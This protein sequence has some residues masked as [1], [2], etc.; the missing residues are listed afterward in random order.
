VQFVAADQGRRDWH[1]DRL[2]GA[3]PFTSG[4]PQP[5]ASGHIRLAMAPGRVV[6]LGF[7]QDADSLITIAQD[8]ALRPQ[9]LLAGQGASLQDGLMM[10]PG[11]GAAFS[12]R[13]G[14]WSAAFALSE[15]RLTATRIDRAAA[16]RSA[17][18]R[19]GRNVGPFALAATL[20]LAL[21]RGSLLGAR[22][23]PAYGV[24]GASHIG[25]GFEGAWQ[26]G[27][28]QISGGAE[29]R[30]VSADLRGG[31]LLAGFGAMGASSAWLSAS[32]QGA[33]DQLSF[34]IA[35]PLRAFGQADVRLGGAPQRLTLTPSGRELSAELGWSRPF[36]GGHLGVHGFARHQP[37]HIANSPADLGAAVRFRFRL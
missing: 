21:E 7:G 13:I 29:V 37:G 19:L 26:Q 25:L 20:R 5:P 18:I 28:V 16:T 23:S 32:W 8:R 24:S 27:P 9:S 14:A 33:H 10:Q 35:Q 31:A 15:A 12:Q 1:G 22:L 3:Q 4:Q 6:A 11:G 17:V 2:T 30:R 36:V 34:T